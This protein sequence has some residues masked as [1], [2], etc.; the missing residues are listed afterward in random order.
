VLKHIIP[1]CELPKIRN[2]GV[3]EIADHSSSYCV[4]NS[5]INMTFVQ[6]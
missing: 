6:R 3:A 2:P 5:I 4:R 1:C